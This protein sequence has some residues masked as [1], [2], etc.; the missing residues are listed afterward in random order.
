MGIAMLH[1]GYFIANI[2]REF[3]WREAEGKLAIDFRPHFGFFTVMKHPLRAHLA[4][5][6]R[7]KGTLKEE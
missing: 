4:V 7:R 2:V 3:E 6:P 5:L 1:M